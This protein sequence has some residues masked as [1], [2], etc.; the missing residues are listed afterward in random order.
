M[1]AVVTLRGG[2]TDVADAVAVHLVDVPAELNP[3]EV[4]VAANRIEGLDEDCARLRHPWQVELRKQIDVDRACSMSSGDTIELVSDAGHHL[5][6]WRCD[7]F[8]WSTI[9]P[10]RTP[11]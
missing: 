8:G 7:P 5:G 4:F 10:E 9:T 11:L 2:S 3:E 6:G 1:H